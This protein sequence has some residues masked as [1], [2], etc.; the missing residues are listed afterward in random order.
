MDTKD[1]ERF[2][3]KV[4]K[5]PDG[6]WMWTGTKNADGYGI[7]FIDKKRYLTHR[8]S[9]EIHFGEIPVGLFICHH[10]DIPGCARPDHLF[11]GTKKDNKQDAMKKGRHAR[12]ETSGRAKLTE[13][14]VREIRKVYHDGGIGII[15]L[16]HLYSV[17]HMAISLAIRGINW[18]EV[19]NEV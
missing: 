19:K 12:G 13:E 5:S 2:W 1:I 7:I 18:K 4:E 3:A 10:C 17:S 15:E 14:K 8:L 11:L 16:G 9:W 6:C